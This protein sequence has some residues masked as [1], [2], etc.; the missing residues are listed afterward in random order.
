MKSGITIIGGKV[1]TDPDLCWRCGQPWRIVTVL[2]MHDGSTRPAP[3]DFGL[4]ACECAAS[5][6]AARDLPLI[7]LRL[8]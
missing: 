2:H 7:Q 3:A 4:R 8:F 6:P 5:P 1:I